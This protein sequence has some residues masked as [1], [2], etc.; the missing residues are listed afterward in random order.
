MLAMLGWTLLVLFAAVV[1]AVLG[2]GGFA[3]NAGWMAK[4][5]FILALIVA[6]V[7]GVARALDGRLRNARR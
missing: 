3:A 2:I 6:V 5:G 4:I 7:V 1:L